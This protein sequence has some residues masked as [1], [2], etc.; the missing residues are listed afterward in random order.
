M[1]GANPVDKWKPHNGQRDPRSFD[2]GLIDPLSNQP[3]IGFCT[4]RH[5]GARSRQHITAPRLLERPGLAS[6]ARHWRQAQ[7]DRPD[8]LIS[9][10]VDRGRRLVTT[11]AC[12]GPDDRQPI[13][14]GPYRRTVRARVGGVRARVGRVGT[15]Q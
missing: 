13:A 15:A 2:S 8:W 11:M 1:H 6:L 5:G 9:T 14:G 7:R 3:R 12:A 4:Y 10:T